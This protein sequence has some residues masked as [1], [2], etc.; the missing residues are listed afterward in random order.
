[1][2]AA[3][4]TKL[5]INCRLHKVKD[6]TTTGLVLKDTGAEASV[7]PRYPN[8][9]AVARAEKLRTKNGTEIHAYGH[10]YLIPDLGLIHK[11]RRGFTVAADLYPIIGADFLQ[12]FAL[13]VSA[14]QGK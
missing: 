5:S 11:L 4:D 2:V 14:R 13:L 6:K 12:P 7:S 1:M 8:K 3:H 9:L 10:R